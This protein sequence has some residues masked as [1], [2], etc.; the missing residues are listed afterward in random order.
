[1]IR[2]G[3]TGA[4]G[5]S[6]SAPTSA[7]RLRSVD[8]FRGAVLALMLLTPATGSL[9]RF[10]LLRHAPWNGLT[11]S[12]LIFPTFL[13]TSGLSLAFLLRPPVTRATKW[14]LVRR[15]V[16]LIVLGLVYNAYGATGFDLDRLRVTGVLQTIGITGAVSA[17]AVL[18]TRR[19][20]GS[21]RHLVLAAVAVAL[22]AAYGLGLWALSDR[23]TPVG[24]CSPYRSFD[25]AVFGAHHVYGAGVPGWDPEGLLPAV[26]ASSLVMVGYL[27][28]RLVRAQRRRLAAAG[29]ALVC[30][31]VVLVG[32]GQLLDGLQPINKRLLTPAFVATA[33]GVALCVFAAFVVVFDVLP[34]PRR[35]L[36]G[37]SWPL[38]ALGRNA[39]VVYLGERLLLES[40]HMVHATDR[41]VEAWLLEDVIPVGRPGVHLAYTAL[42]LAVL[43]L[44]TGVLHRRRWY[45]AL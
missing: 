26:T 22:P 43:L 8:A 31:G 21:D 17:V 13:V 20:D 10:P 15:C 5:S 6:S 23:C 9:E 42:L 32:V 18:A 12:D 7:G 4:M 34:S 3:D 27:A 44:V 45:V 19:A 2:L 33:A 29:L 11:I 35:L 36:D 14:R 16:L 28:G 37:A 41:T 38:V 24:A 39:L 40:A 1:M 30:G 25:V